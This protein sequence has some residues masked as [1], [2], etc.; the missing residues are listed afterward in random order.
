MRQLPGAPALPYR[1][2]RL[3]GELRVE[4]AF[5]FPR[6]E[7]QYVFSYASDLTVGLIYVAL[8]TT[9]GP[10]IACGDDVVGGKEGAENVVYRSRDAGIT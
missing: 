7:G 2:Y 4:P 5:T 6:T 3:G 9:P 10:T 1:L 8:C